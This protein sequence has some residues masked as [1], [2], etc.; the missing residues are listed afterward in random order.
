MINICNH[1]IL[2]F[3]MVRMGVIGCCLQYIV[4]RKHISQDR[5]ADG[6]K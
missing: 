2:C 3:Y 4:R 5:D 1:D 6:A